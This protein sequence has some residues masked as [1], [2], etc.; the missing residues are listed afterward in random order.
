MSRLSRAD[1]MTQKQISSWGMSNKLPLSEC[2]GVT[3]GMFSPSFAGP[4]ACGNGLSP[5]IQS[6][7]FL[8]SFP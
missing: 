3:L 7:A 8:S 2:I 1:F 6:L 4:G 5:G